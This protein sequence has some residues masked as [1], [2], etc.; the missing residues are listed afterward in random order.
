LPSK[1][2]PDPGKVKEEISFRRQ[3]E[4]AE[5]IHNFFFISQTSPRSIANKNTSEKVKNERIP[6]AVHCALRQHPFQYQMKRETTAQEEAKR[7]RKIIKIAILLFR[8]ERISC[9]FLGEG[10]RRSKADLP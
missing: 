6:A 10:R 1:P 8:C 2:D 4:A 9:S 5:K 7:A 3:S